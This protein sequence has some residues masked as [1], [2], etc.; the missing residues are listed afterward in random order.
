MMKRK[1]TSIIS[2]ILVLVM[3]FSMSTTAFASEVSAEQAG[4]YIGTI[5]VA[6]EY[7]NDV[8]YVIYDDTI[9]DIPIYAAKE[10]EENAR[11]LTNVATLT[12]GIG[13]GYAVFQFTPTN[14]GI[15][16]LTVGFTGSFTTYKSGLRYGYNNYIIPVTSGTVSASTIGTGSL[17]GS[18]S[19]LG[20]ET[21]SILQGF[22]W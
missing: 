12:I 17:S 3:C 13:D 14:L 1:I 19:V 10:G 6:D 15:A 5:T 9:T 16:L 21:A 2:F 7:G 4:D 20:Y 11:A 8:Q 18:Y 22:S